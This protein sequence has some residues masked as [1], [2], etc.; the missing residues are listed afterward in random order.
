MEFG[1]VLFKNGWI[2]GG[3]SIEQSLPGEG[4][5]GSKWKRNSGS[6]TNGKLGGVKGQLLL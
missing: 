5:S 6:S 1:Q 3:L 2:L 4:L